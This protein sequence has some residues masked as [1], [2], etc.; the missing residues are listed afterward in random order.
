MTTHGGLATGSVCRGRHAGSL[1][2]LLRE[3]LRAFDPCRACARP[4]DGDPAVAQL[5]GEARNERRLRPDHDEVDPEL[6][7]ER[8]ERGVVVGADGVAVGECRDAGVAG[9]GVQLSEPSLRDSDQ[10][11]ACSRPPD[12]TT[13][14]R[15][16]R[17]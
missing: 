14:S 10:A 17:S 13:S 9:S 7:R 4:E 12:P 3:R 8:D 5:V 16:P 11:S 1:H 6:A 15:T 2:H